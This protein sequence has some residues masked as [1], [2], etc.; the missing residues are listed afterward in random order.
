MVHSPSMQTLVV[1]TNR[2]VKLLEAKGFSRA[3]A[4]GVTEA[5]AQIDLSPLTTKADLQEL[6]LDF[7]KALHRQTWAL[8][9]LMFAQGA[10]IIAV[11]QY[12][13]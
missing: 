4:E 6:K 9:G 3:Q 7:E 8:V 11:L 5:L 1:D 2:V 10:F 13:K 12:L